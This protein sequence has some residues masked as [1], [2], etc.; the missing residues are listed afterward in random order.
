ML[1]IADIKNKPP[2]SNAH[3]LKAFMDTYKD[4]QPQDTDIYRTSILGIGGG[5]L[6]RSE[7][8]SCWSLQFLF[9][10]MFEKN[11]NKQKEAGNGPLFRDV[12]KTIYGCI[13]YA[14]SGVDP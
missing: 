12:Y 3:K 4:G 10:K 14:K 9:C 13:F 6:Q 8:E 11:K 7:F 1:E 5:L 2:P